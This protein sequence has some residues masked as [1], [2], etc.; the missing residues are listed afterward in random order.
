VLGDEYEALRES[1]KRAESYYTFLKDKETEAKLKENE[2]LQVAFIQVIEP[3]RPPTNPV[4]SF[5]IQIFALGGVLSLVVSGVL[6]FVL[7]YLESGQ[8]KRTHD[9]TLVCPSG[10]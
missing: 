3:A 8:T 10:S 1:I 4:S 5:N 6:A 7:E 9:E 2:V